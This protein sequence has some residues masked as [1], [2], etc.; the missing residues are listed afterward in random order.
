M[1]EIKEKREIRG[2]TPVCILIHE[3]GNMIMLM[4]FSISKLEEKYDDISQYEY[5]KY[6][7]EDTKEMINMITKAKEINTVSQL[8]KK[9]VEIK[10]FINKIISKQKPVCDAKHIKLSCDIDEKLLEKEN[11]KILCD[12]Y[13]LERAIENIIKNSV[14]ELEACIKKKKLINVHIKLNYNTIIKDKKIDNEKELIIEINNNGRKIGEELLNNIFSFFVTDK[15]K[16]SGIGLSVCNE[17]VKAHGGKIKVVS[18]EVS[19]TTFVI[20]LP[21]KEIKN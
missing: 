16:G 8:C 18:D 4:D 6:L 12:E 21:Y 9:K 2:N 19:G 11:E 13:K 1:E 14:E 15:E 20:S 3:I 17:T 10:Y 7:K 5:F